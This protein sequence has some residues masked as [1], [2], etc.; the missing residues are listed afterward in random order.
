MIVSQCDA[1]FGPGPS[2]VCD[3]ER[4]H[5]GQHRGFDERYQVEVFWSRSDAVRLEP[6]QDDL[7]WWRGER[8]EFLRPYIKIA[9]TD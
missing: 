2:Y 8:Y 3:R 9:S 5:N 1:T 4:G 7:A 6:R